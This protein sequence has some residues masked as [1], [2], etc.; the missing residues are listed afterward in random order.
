[1][2]KVLARP[3]QP[4]F[5]DVFGVESHLQRPALEAADAE[6]QV[7]VCEV[8][9]QPQPRFGWAFARAAG[10]GQSVDCAG[11]ARAG[12]DVAGEVG[13]L[14][15]PPAEGMV[16]AVTRILKDE[17]EAS[18]ME[19]IEDTEKNEAQKVDVESEYG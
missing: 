19:V 10:F 16:R 9:G 3:F 11:E 1:M 5:E 4:H 6:E 13:V 17:G 12:R 15:C 7:Q 18:K 14:P 2:L 8:V